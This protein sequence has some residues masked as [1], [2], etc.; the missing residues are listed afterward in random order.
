M[1]FANQKIYQLKDTAKRQGLIY[2][3]V[4]YLMVGLLIYLQWS[5]SSSAWA[6]VASV[7]GLGLPILMLLDW[8]WQH[9]GFWARQ[10]PLLALGF[11]IFMM[12]V[13]LY[14]RSMHMLWVGWL[15]VWILLLLSWRQARWLLLLVPMLFIPAIVEFDINKRGSVLTMMVISF[16]VV[17]A[18]GWMDHR[19]YSGLPE[20]GEL[21][22]HSGLYNESQLVQDVKREVPRAERRGSR[23]LIAVVSGVKA[24]RSLFSVGSSVWL[25][26]VAESFSKS[27]AAYHT[28][29][30]CNDKMVVLLPLASDQDMLMMEDLLI[31]QNHSQDV[32][33][34]LTMQWLE[35]THDGTLKGLLS[36]LSF[37]LGREGHFD[38]D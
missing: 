17:W 14:N 33:V 4:G 6:L 38:E 18:W 31:A 8:R 30:E 3:G 19:Y 20:S 21:D 1:P 37:A 28:L 27:L 11:F 25:K 26:V 13:G 5:G 2:S 29:Y 24:N 12:T 36:Q 15:P 7:I 16:A 23:L 34:R 9:R 10:F 32:Q 22:W 35:Y